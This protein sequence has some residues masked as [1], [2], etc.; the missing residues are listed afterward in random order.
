[1]AKDKLKSKL[2]DLDLRIIWSNFLVL[3]MEKLNEIS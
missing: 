1:M 3:Q 2:M